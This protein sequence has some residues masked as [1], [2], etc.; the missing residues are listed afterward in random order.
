MLTAL[1]RGKPD[2]LPATLHQWQDYHLN[3]YMDGV[4]ALEA[5]K[6]VGLDASIQHFQPAGQFWLADPEQY[7]ACATRDWQDEVRVVDADPDHR[8]LRHTIHTPRG[9]L[10]YATESNRKTTWVTDYLIKD[11]DDIE[12]IRDFMPWPKLD[13]AEVSRL[14]DEVG[15]HGILRG[16]VWG[17]QAGCW[18]HACCLKDVTEMIMMC[19][20]DPD[21]VHEL[22][23]ILL[24]KKL[25]SIEAMKGAQFDIVETGGGSASSTVISPDLHEEFCLPYDRQMHDAL[26]DVGLMA[27]YHT[28][29]GTVGIEEL[30]VANGC[31]AS[32]TLAPV[33]IGGNQE[34]WEFAEKIKGRVAL[35]GG[36]DQ[37]NVVT[38]GSPSLIHAKVNEAFERVGQNGGYVCSLSDHFFDAPVENLV[39]FA[40]AARECRY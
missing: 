6:A 2:R 3:T 36:I 1:R 37:F 31:D 17:D 11:P 18:Q 26:H 14:Y 7:A 28:C 21:W 16:F 38:D 8:V 9:D 39:A 12:L 40:K 23:H 4:T 33:S 20:D 30:I 35:I 15:D 25:R 22:L 13:L 24:E 27:T 10:T 5:F 32:E 34:P 19:F 29:G